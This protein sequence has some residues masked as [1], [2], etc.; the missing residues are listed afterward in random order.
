VNAAYVGVTDAQPHLELYCGQLGFAVA[1]TGV[2]PAAQAAALWGEGIGDTEVTVLAAAGAAHGRIVLLRVPGAAPAEYPHTADFGL[3]GIDVYTRD[4]EE[5]HRVLS[6]AGYRWMT[7][8]DTWKVPLGDTLVTVT[9]GFCQGPE[10][11]DI[12]FVQPAAPRGTAAWDAEPDRFYTELTSVVCHVPDFDAEVGFWGPDGLG[13]SPWYD[14]SFS[15]PGLD[16]MATLPPGTVMRLC[17]LAGPETARI[18]VTQ[19]QNRSTGTD[20]RPEQRTGRHLGHSGWLVRTPDLDAALTAAERSGGRLLSPAADG[21]SVLFGGA[22]VAM[23]DTPNG[24]PV[25]LHETTR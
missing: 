9:Q 5:S 16:A 10:G 18:E 14:V 12:V 24:I 21:P 8:P 4:I 7:P 19:I 25:T 11:T 15:H 1:E 23:V 22:R 6:A 3:A 17:F 2:I 13:L 20:R